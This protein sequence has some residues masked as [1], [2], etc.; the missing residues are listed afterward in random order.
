MP[1][2]LLAPLGV[3]L[4]ALLFG[5]L[6]AVAQS[7]GLFLPGG[8]GAGFTLEHYATTLADPHLL[9]SV[10]LSLYISLAGALLA[11]VC[12][13]LLSY[14]LVVTGRDRGFVFTVV[15][16]PIFFPWMIT[17]LITMDMFSGGGVLASMARAIGWEAAADFVS[18]FLYEPSSIG[19]ILAYTWACTPFVAY[20]IITV[21]GNITSTLGE[22][23]RTL[24]ASTAQTFFNVTLPL[25]LP[26]I[27]NIFLITLVSLFGNYEIPL[28][29]GMTTPRALP[30]DIFYKYSNLGLE[31]RPQVMA[32]STLMLLI[33]LV[34]IV[35]F[36]WF[37]QRD[38]RALVDVGETS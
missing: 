8:R 26:T 24:G 35:V 4:A 20:F 30:V 21:M 10:G 7:F 22:A 1:L 3:L 29:L 38:R 11:T 33:S 36:Y 31:G 28:L 37:F 16:F 14:A 5:L 12:A 9:E 32:T 15:K 34:I 23:A 19:I 2:V 13:T 25:C 27:K 17:A 18:G 6:F